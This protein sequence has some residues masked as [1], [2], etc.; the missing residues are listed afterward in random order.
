MK[1]SQTVPIAIILGGLIVATA[2]Y[3]SVKAN[4][5][6]TASGTG[7]PTV[8]RPVDSSDHILGNPL[9]PVKIIE[10]SDFDC[11][12]CKDFDAVLH[13]I[14]ADLGA[15]GKVAWVFRQFPIVELHPNAVKHAEASDCVAKVGGNDAFWKF[16]TALF[17]NQPTD[18]ARY[19]E[20]AQAAGI[21]G[22][23]FAECYQNAASTVDAHIT[24]DI[25]NG[26]AAGANGTPYTLI[27]VKGQAPFVIPGA[28]PY[29]DV[30][31]AVQSMLSKAGS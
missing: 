25:E 18:P 8:V 21:R 9:A 10:Y 27:V 23:G 29:A 20:L 28:Y 4:N 1:T 11:T 3:M 6:S 14:V 31:D 2:V 22:N 30:K 13:Q 17:Q 19:G 5:P 24:A 26:K 16:A 12:H 7:D 15:T